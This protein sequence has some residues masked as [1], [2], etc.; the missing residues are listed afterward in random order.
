MLV[1]A[2]D[3]GMDSGQPQSV[4]PL[5]KSGAELPKRGRV[6]PF[7]VDLAPGETSSCRT[8]W[9]RVTF[10]GVERWNK[11]QIS[12]TPGK[13]SRSLGVV[14]ALIG[15]LGSLFIR[16]RRIWVRARQGDGRHPRRGGRPRPLRRRRRTDAELVETWS[17]RH[18]QTQEE[19]S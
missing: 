8:G 11:I 7:R 2:G 17:A 12:R 13:R 18:L 15:L 3:L 16:P 6:D 10:D 1:Y 4:Y 19:K 14:L 5:D 9:A